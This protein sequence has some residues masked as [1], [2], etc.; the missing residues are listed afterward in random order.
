MQP[1]GS[2][3]GQSLARELTADHN[4]LISIKRSLSTMVKIL[5]EGTRDEVR[6]NFRL[7]KEKVKK[8]NQLKQRQDRGQDEKARL[9]NELGE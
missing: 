1:S 5:G 9:A 4:A 7:Q 3:V 6:C 8:K 2:F